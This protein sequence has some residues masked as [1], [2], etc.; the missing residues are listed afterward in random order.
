MFH[1]IASDL[2]GT[3]LNSNHQ[4]TSFTKKIIQLLTAHNNIHFIFAT[5]RHY[6]NVIKIRDILKTNSYM[7]TSNG[8][9]I[10]NDQGK[11]IEKH[12]FNTEIAADLIK[13][14]YY[15]P[16]IITNIFRDNE[17]LINRKYQFNK[18]NNFQENTI[19]YRIYKKNM[20]SLQEICKIYF[21]SNNQ[22][23]LLS[24]EK[25]LYEKWGNKINISFSLPTCLEIMPQGISK[26]YA[27]E[28]VV[29][30]LGYTLQNCI[31]FG[32]GMNDKEM[33]SI[34]GKG[35]IM[36]NAQ[37][38]LKNTLPHLEIIGSNKNDA[39]P[40]YLKNMYHL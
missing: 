36:L 38:R 32:D 2:D 9:R 1:I 37:Q 19:S 15:D 4:I 18:K 7:I 13:I 10:H 28:K 30:L 33:L 17:W 6:A 16:H 31:A 3:L 22:K 14:A 40:H 20:S 25:K 5:G 29:Y 34:T 35:C 21:T 39:V 8:A 27:L 12:N 23:K 24:L 26:G 11:I